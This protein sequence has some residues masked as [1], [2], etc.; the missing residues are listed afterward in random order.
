[1]ADRGPTVYTELGQIIPFR[2]KDKAAD[3]FWS[4]DYN[5]RKAAERSWGTL[6]RVIC[7]FWMNR[8]WLDKQKNRALHATY[9]QSAHSHESPTEYVIRKLR[10]LNLIGNYSDSQLIIEIMNGAP[11][12]WNRIIDARRCVDF[13][14]F[15]T[16]IKYHEDSLISSNISEDRDIECRLRLLEQDSSRNRRWRFN[17]PRNNPDSPKVNAN[18]VGSHPSLGTPQWPQDDSVVSKGRTPETV[19]ARPC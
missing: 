4:L 15:Q 11:A 13:I 7:E 6:R 8:I 9:R 2:L 16:A 18:L 5:Y 1:M 19:G 17:T 10:L 3:W 14:D 12:Y